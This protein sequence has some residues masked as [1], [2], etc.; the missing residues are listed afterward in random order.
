[1]S[2]QGEDDGLRCPI[3]EK[4]RHL[5]YLLV[6]P[7]S[8]KPSARESA[9]LYCKTEDLPDSLAEERS[10]KTIENHFIHQFEPHDFNGN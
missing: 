10:C 2:N 9:L 8:S 3:R 4:T 6:T 5:A 7:D 1:M